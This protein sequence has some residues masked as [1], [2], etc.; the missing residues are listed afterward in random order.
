MKKMR[1]GGEEI[2]GVAFRAV[3]K[4]SFYSGMLGAIAGF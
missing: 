2:R 4:C 1:E 3:D